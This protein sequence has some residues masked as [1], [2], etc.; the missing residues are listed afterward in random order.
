VL[1]FATIQQ[2]AKKDV[3]HNLP[4]WIVEDSIIPSDRNNR[5]AWRLDGS[6]G[7]PDGFGGI[8]NEFD[9]ELLINYLQGVIG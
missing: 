3:P 2:I 9:A 8:S 7:M 4:Y 1:N 6:E 5:N